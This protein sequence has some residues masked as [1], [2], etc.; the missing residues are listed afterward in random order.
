MVTTTVHDGVAP[1]GSSPALVRYVDLG[2]LRVELA[3]LPD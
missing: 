1:V 2:T 3:E